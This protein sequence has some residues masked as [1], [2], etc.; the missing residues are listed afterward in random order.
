MRENGGL[1]M[2]RR[3]RRRSKGQN[4]GL[5]DEEGIS[6]RKGSLPDFVMDVLLKH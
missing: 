6:Q 2:E 3:L 5:G 4:Y 1:G